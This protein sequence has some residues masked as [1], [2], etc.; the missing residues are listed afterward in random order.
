MVKYIILGQSLLL[1]GLF[2]YLFIKSR[3]QYK[4]LYQVRLDPLGLQISPVPEQTDAKP[5][6][7]G[8]GDSRMRSWSIKQN[9]DRWT[10]KNW[11]INSQT[12]EQVLLRMQLGIENMNPSVV[13]VQVGINDLKLIPLFPDRA[14]AITSKCKTNISMMTNLAVQNGSKVILTTIFPHAT[15]GLARSMI[16]DISVKEAIDEVN[17]FIKGLAS[18]DVWVYDSHARLVRRSDGVVDPEYALDFL[19]INEAGYEAL[20]QEIIPIITDALSQ[21]QSGQ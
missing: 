10:F 1:I 7:V 9:S 20:N 16:T 14:E 6:V 19:H 3:Q 17:L 13:I 11:G 18:A 21:Q 12:S 2:G 15:P 8:I 4:E 5:M